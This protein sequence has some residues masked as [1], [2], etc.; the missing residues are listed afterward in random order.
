M[1]K[2]LKTI[3]FKTEFEGDQVVATLTPLSFEDALRYEDLEVVPE[4]DSERAKSIAHSKVS[5]MIAQTLAGFLPKYC[6]ELKGL[7]DAEGKV[8]TIHEVCANAYF[9]PLIIEMGRA[10][11]RAAYPQRPKKP[12]A[13]LG[14]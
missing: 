7:N 5:T 2:F 6:L 12:V 11:V 4:D 1:S 10:L 13:T 3:E 8:L 9:G 14:S